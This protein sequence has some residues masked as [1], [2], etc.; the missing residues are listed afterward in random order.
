MGD[1]QITDF[2]A[3]QEAKDKKLRQYEEELEWKNLRAQ[4]KEPRFSSMFP[5]P[6]D[7]EIRYRKW[8]KRQDEINEWKKLI[9]QGKEPCFSPTFGPRDEDKEARYREMVREEGWRTL[10]KQ[11]KEPCFSSSF[12]PH[13]EIE[14][15]VKQYKEWL[16]NEKLR[17]QVESSAAKRKRPQKERGGR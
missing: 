10:R 3:C 13:E 8:E 5:G 12:A 9:E 4:G 1:K 11:G 17:E 6:T 14:K 7:T 2:F 15:D 16:D